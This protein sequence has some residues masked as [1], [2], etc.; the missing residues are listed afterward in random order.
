MYIH[1]DGLNQKIENLRNDIK[2]TLQRSNPGGYVWLNVNPCIE[3][4]KR[5]DKNNIFM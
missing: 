1:Y 4:Y 2:T 3:D 5:W